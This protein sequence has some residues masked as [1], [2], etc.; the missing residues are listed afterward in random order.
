[1]TND[2]RLFAVLLTGYLAGQMLIS[3]RWQLG[4]FR[5]SRTIEDPGRLLA[6]VLLPT[7]TEWQFSIAGA[8]III[9]CVLG[10]AGLRTGFA[11]AAVGCLAYF[12]QIRLL[13]TVQRKV[14]LLPQLLV[15]LAITPASVGVRPAPADGWLM[16][17]TKVLLALVYVSAGLMKLQTSGLRWADGRALQTFLLAADLRYDVPR[18]RALATRRQVC[19]ALSTA[20]LAFELLG[21]L[22]LFSRRGEFA[23][24]AVGLALHAGMFVFLRVN[25]LKYLGPAYLV[26]AAP[27]LAGIIDQVVRSR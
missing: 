11:L 7:L 1:V 13:D 2:V 20:V 4:Y 27:P 10:A 18:A 14:N 22:L 17:T 21:W 25:Y 19:A 8:A 26:F 15:L 9:G 6:L 12:S 3:W 23:F 5:V 16:L 24:A